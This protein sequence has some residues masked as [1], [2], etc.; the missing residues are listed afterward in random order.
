M[1]FSSNSLSP[2]AILDKARKAVPAVNYALGVAGVAAAAALV[3]LLVGNTNSSIILLSSSFVG[4]VLLF[5]FSKLVVSPAPS[6]QFAGIVLVW[7]ILAFFATF[8]LFTTTAFVSGWPCNWAEILGLKHQCAA[9]VQKQFAIEP[10][11]TSYS[12]SELGVLIT[13]PNGIL[14][15]DT[16]QRKQR[17]LILRDGN[18]QE[19]VKISRT[20]LSEQKDV[21][22]ARENEVAQLKKMSFVVTYIAPEKDQNWSNWYVLSGVSHG[23]EFYFRR[24]HCPDSIV[25][26]EF[27]YA[28]EL[29]PLFDSLVTKMTRELAM[30][31]CG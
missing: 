26:I 13:F 11:Y 27:T 6:I 20:V 16:T 23:T 17:E 21:K 18:G 25:S 19:V 12:S 22:I 4:M 10:T 8:L 15:L 30:S 31:N 3:T 14:S 2:M 29:A 5:V 24:W 9:L 1:D 7:M 28:K